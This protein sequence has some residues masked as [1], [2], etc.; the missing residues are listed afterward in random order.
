LEAGKAEKPFPKDDD[1]RWAIGG[2]AEAVVAAEAAT[3]V[4][5]SQSTICNRQ[6]VNV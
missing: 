6:F 3:T 4:N 2:R 1:R 5:T